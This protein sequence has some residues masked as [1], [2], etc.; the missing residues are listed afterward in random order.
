MRCVHP[1]RA[2]IE[3]L[4]AAVEHL[5][6]ALASRTVIG[7]AI[8]IPM[9]RL[10]LDGDAPF[11]YLRRCSQPHNKLHDICAKRV[12]TGELPLPRPDSEPHREPR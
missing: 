11:D 12:A 9:S 7:K 4:E 2:R 3:E 10:E 1:Q 6:R 5:H 8:E